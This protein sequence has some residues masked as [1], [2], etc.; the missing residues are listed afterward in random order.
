MADTCLIYGDS[1]TW[2]TTNL[3]FAAKYL[4]ERTGGKIIRLISADGGKW[5]PV[6]P[7]VALGIIEPFYVAEVPAPLVLIRKLSIGYWPDKLH[8]GYWDAKTGKLL[9]PTPE[10]W[11]RVGGYLIEGLT[12]L[13]DVEMED[14]RDKQR[15]IGEDSVGNFTESGP[16]GS[17]DEKFA[18]NCRAHYGFVQRE[19]LARLKS[20][21][22]LPCDR[23]LFSAHEA[24]GT[25]EDTQ[26]A[27]R[28]PALTGQKGTD[29]VP[30]EVGDCIHFE[31]YVKDV[32]EEDP[33]TKGKFTY[34]QT[35]VRA[36]FMSHPDP[37]FKDILYKCKPR[38]PPETVGQLLAK[39]R[40]GFFE[41]T[42]EHGLDEFLR[43]EDEL[44]TRATDGQ[45]KWK[46]AIDLQIKAQK[47]KAA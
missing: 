40:G 43:F 42:T 26:A 36:Y 6:E 4:Y 27:I 31:Q 15:K 35:S 33:I 3:G 22:A 14:L 24:K 41:P 23:V 19:M 28:G 38:V 1:G 34:K 7:L 32:T 17:G 2:K 20:F 25:D 16:G 44:L 46:E 13:S 12:S 9:P 37:V 18:A 10:V 47:E 21:S 29:K 30:K 45:R 5:K 11:K 8:N 39:Y